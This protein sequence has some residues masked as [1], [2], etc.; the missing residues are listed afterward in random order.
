VKAELYRKFAFVL[1][2][3][4]FRDVVQPEQYDPRAIFRDVVPIYSGQANV[5]LIDIDQGAP[6]RRVNTFFSL[7]DKFPVDDERLRKKV[8]KRVTEEFP[9]LVG[10]TDFIVY[11]LHHVTGQRVRLLGKTVQTAD[12]MIIVYLGIDPR[13]HP[14]RVHT[15]AHEFGHAMGLPHLAK[16]DTLMFPNILARSN[17]IVGGHIEQ[18]STGQIFPNP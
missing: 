17:R 16:L 6:M 10:K 2:S 12:N 9:D 1:L 18:L 15:M 3:D 4:P 13:D 14:G 5:T 11:I 8:D 7:R